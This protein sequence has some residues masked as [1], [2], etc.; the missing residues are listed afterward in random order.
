MRVTNAARIVLLALLLLPS[1]ARAERV[2]LAD[3]GE[4]L[5]SPLVVYETFDRFY[6]GPNEATYPPGR[7]QQITALVASEY[8]LL[9]GVSLDMTI[10]YVRA[11]GD[12]GVNDGLYDTNL[13]INF[14]ILDE[15]EW[16]SEWVP[17]V[18]FRFGA[19]IAGTYQAIGAFFPGIPGDKAS[20]LEGEFSVGKLLPHDFGVTGAIGIRAREKNV[21]MD[22]HLRVGGFKTFFEDV[23]LSFAFDM[24]RSTSGID[25]G[26][27]FTPDQFRQLR[28]DSGNIEVGLGFGDPWGLYW[29]LYYAH[30]V[31]GRNTG[32]KDI[33]GLVITVPIDFAKD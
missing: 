17:S 3:K 27:G 8:G 19:I 30:T 13:G 16:D 5:V 7:Y 22:W 9:D 29:S 20:G 21:P 31:T 12:P 26:P 6:M 15:F 4:L 25:L 28:E 11:F 33:A 2:W 24:W 10:G 18:S 14:E 1:S 23:S 32:I